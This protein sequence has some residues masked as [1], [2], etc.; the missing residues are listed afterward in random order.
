MSDYEELLNQT[1]SNNQ[2]VQAC[3]LY[4]DCDFIVSGLKVL[5]WFNY[6]ITLPF[7]N[8]VE[9]SSQKDLLTI[10]PKLYDDLSVNILETLHDFKVNYSFDVLEPTSPIEKHI[11]NLCSIKAASNLATQRGREYGFG[12][13]D[14]SSRATALHTLDPSLLPYLPTDNLDCERDLAKFDKL[15]QRSAACSNKTFTGKGI[16][17]KMTLYKSSPVSVEKFGKNT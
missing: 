12:P 14:A 3:I 15:A 4:L 8:M 6:K 10:L 7:L 11:L 5:S 17:D 1:K 9:L 16:R 2:L 13:G